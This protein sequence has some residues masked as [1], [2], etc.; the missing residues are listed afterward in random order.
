MFCFVKSKGNQTRYNSDQEWHVCANP[1]NPKICPVLALAC[2][3]FS[4]PGIFL[5][6]ADDEVVEGGGVGTQ[7]G[8]LFLGGN[9]Y[10]RFMDCLHRIFGKVL[11]RV[12]CVGHLAWQSGIALGKE[13][14]KQPCLQWID[15]LAANGVHMSLC[16]VEYGTC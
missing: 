11:Q 7:K 5:A 9:Q 8:C 1:H 14:H 15:G 12:L 6:A 3:I 2:Y 16:H 13:R 10:N 4:N